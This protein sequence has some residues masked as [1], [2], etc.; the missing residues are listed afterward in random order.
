MANVRQAVITKIP[1]RS[2]KLAVWFFFVFILLPVL[3]EVFDKQ[4][5]NEWINKSSG[6]L[7][8]SSAE[9]S[10]TTH[11][12]MEIENLAILITVCFLAFF[13]IYKFIVYDPSDRDFHERYYL[14]ILQQS[15]RFG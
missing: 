10:R 4:T 3:E 15:Y 9:Y 12:I 5:V 1:T 8:N 6:I 7:R 13:A 14:H 11:T 2:R